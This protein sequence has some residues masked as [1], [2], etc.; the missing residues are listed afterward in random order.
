MTTPAQLPLQVSLRADARLDAL[1]AGPNAWLIDWLRNEWLQGT[2]T[3]LF[4][5]GAAG[6]GLTHVQQAICHW[7]ESQGLSAFYLSL[8]EVKHEPADLL[9]EL[10]GVAVL[11][12]DD[13]DAVLGDEDWDRALFNVF[14]SMRDQG[15]RLVLASHRSLPELQGNVLPDLHSRLSWGMRAQLKVP[16]DDAWVAAIVWLAEQH[17]MSLS[18]DAA[19]YLAYRGPREWAGLTTTM[20]ALDTASLAAQRRLTQPFIKSVMGW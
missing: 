15:Q 10:S 18:D 9:H 19:Q 7:A 12:L 16:D 1:F 14:N 8:N 17:G 11:C 5:H 3:S 4:L 6:S 20:Q 2:E 13:L